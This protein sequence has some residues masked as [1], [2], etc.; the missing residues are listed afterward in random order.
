TR[1]D[2]S[3]TT[4]L[5]AGRLGGYEGA[6]CGAAP[7]FHASLLVVLALLVRRAPRVGRD[8]LARARHRLQAPGKR[9]HGDRRPARILTGGARRRYAGLDLDLRVAQHLAQERSVRVR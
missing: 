1:L 7:C 3:L 5:I 6:A 8:A 2:P 9:V 4:M